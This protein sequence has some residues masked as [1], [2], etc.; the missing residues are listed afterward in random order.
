MAAPG[1]GGGEGRGGGHMFYIGLY[2]EQHEK[3]FLFE[4]TRPK[5]LIFGM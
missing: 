3:I 1:G 5:A 2:M 4:T